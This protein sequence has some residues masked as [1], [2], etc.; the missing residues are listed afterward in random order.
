MGVMIMGV[1]LKRWACLIE[2]EF[3]IRLIQLMSFKE[4]VERDLWVGVCGRE[5]MW[6][7]GGIC[8]CDVGMDECGGGNGMI[9]EKFGPI[10]TPYYSSILAQ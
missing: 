9:I 1:E 10:T 6:W 8:C 5:L 2:I 3:Y 4:R 7:H